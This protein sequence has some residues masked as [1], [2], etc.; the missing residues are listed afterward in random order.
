MVVVGIDRRRP[1][2]GRRIDAQP[3]VAF[4]NSCTELAQFDGHRRDAIGLLDAPGADVGQATRPVSEQGQYRDGHGRI[5]N[6]V[7][8]GVDRLEP[9]RVGLVGK[10]AYLDPVGACRQVGP[11]LRQR[12]DEAHIALDAVA[13]DP[14]DAQGPATKRTGGEKVRGRRGVAFN[15]QGARASIGGAGS[16]VKGAPVFARHCNAK[17]L[18]QVQG[19]LDIGFGDQFAHHFDGHRF[20]GFACQERKRHQERGQKLARHIAAHRD[21]ALESDDGRADFQGRITGLAGVADIGTDR[22]QPVDQ[23]TDRALMHARHTAQTIVPAIDGQRRRQ[24]PDR[25]AGIAHEEIGFTHREPALHA[26]YK[27]ISNVLLAS[28]AERPEGAQHDAGIVGIQQVGNPGAAISQRCQQQ[29]AVGNAFRPGQADAAA[30]MRDTL[31]RQARHQ[32]VRAAAPGGASPAS[33]ESS[34]A[35]RASRALENTT[36]SACASAA[37]IMP[38]TAAKRTMY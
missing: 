22:R 23:I 37:A 29:A 3:I 34:Q 38:R 17:A 35:W 4:V 7:E 27:P 32:L 14:L 24:W 12:V 30:G 36:S 21:R 26:V 16:D 33:M 20:G 9:G 28:Y 25:G 2:L 13:A 15:M 18:H 8:V 5:R 11:H 1:Q 6:M 19:D 31:E 10:P